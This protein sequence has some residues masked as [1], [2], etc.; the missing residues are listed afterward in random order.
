MVPGCFRDIFIQVVN[1]TVWA[2][3]WR[4]L[5]AGWTHYL[6]HNAHNNCRDRSTLPANSARNARRLAGGRSFPP[7]WL[8]TFG[9]WKGLQ[10]L[11]F[12][13]QLEQELKCSNQISVHNNF[14]PFL[15][16][17]ADSGRFRLFLRT[18]L[19][20]KCLTQIIKQLRKYPFLLNV[21]DNINVRNSFI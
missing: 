14:L 9:S 6:R 19:N 3:V 13:L 1:R 12:R 16:T 2:T 4:R 17:I 15:Q 8:K 10:F 5:G 20:K 21:S 7:V 18:A 11:S